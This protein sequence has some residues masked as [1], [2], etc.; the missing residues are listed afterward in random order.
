MLALRKYLKTLSTEEQGSFANRCDTSIGYLR[1]AISIGQTLNA[2]LVIAIERE[3]DGAV[4]CEQLRPDI[5]W[6]TL[7]TRSAA[8]PRSSCAKTA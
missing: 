1:K 2:E 4:R 6:R 7:R 8:S 3:S 5:D